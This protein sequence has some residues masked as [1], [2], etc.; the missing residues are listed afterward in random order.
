MKI[1]RI[2]LGLLSR[3]RFYW[4]VFSLPSASSFMTELSRFICFASLLTIN[5]VT[6][7]SKIEMAFIAKITSVVP[8]KRFFLSWRSRVGSGTSLG[9]RKCSRSFICTLEV[10]SIK[11]IVSA[12]LRIGTANQNKY[13]ST[14]KARW[15]S[16]YRTMLWTEL[17]YLKANK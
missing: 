16:L 14:F 12:R 6:V 1:C 3:S 4:S 11:A 13:L 5:I 8:I 9:W 17:K 15:G 10:M 7:I 2:V